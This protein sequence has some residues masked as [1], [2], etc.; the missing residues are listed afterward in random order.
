MVK[1]NVFI[2]TFL[3]LAANMDTSNISPTGIQMLLRNSL[4]KVFMGTFK[5]RRERKLSPIMNYMIKTW[6][7]ILCIDLY[8]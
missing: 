8:R 2:V 6:I 7:E 5:R 4:Q 1:D 3:I